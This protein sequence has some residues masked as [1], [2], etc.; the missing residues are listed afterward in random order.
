MIFDL[1]VV[2]AGPAGSSTAAFAARQGLRVIMLDRCKF[3][4]D[5]A[6]G[7]GVT[8]P[9]LNV[10][11]RLG[12]LG[13]VEFGGFHQGRGFIFTSPGG[14]VFRCESPHVDGLRPY[15]YNVP[16]RILDYLLVQ[17]AMELGA[18]L[19]EGFRVVE[20]APSALEAGRIRSAD[21]REVKARL[22]VMASGSLS[23]GVR[24]A[25]YPPPRSFG[26]KW[27]AGVRAY[28]DGV[29]G[30]QPGYPEII[31]LPFSAAGYAWIFPLGP[32]RANVG[33]GI[34][35][36]DL[37]AGAPPL[38]SLFQQFVQRHMGPGGRFARARQDG[39]LRGGLLPMG[40]RFGRTVAD[41][42]M[43]VGDAAGFVDPLTGEGI[44]Y[45][46]RSGELAA[47]QGLEALRRGDVSAGA[48]R[49]YEAQWRKDFGWN[50]WIG[51]CLRPWLAR[52]SLIER[53]FKSL[54]RDV[55]GS[56]WLAGIIG[57]LYPKKMLLSPRWIS[58]IIFPQRWKMNV[59]LRSNE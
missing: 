1:A 41:G 57:N 25:G 49:G 48:L 56:Q 16:R 12:V 46:L 52:G 21:G 20:V 38:R 50:L 31:F 34:L 37:S 24:V 28:F 59:R 11:E 17:R 32:E 33:V 36:G 13:T 5:K 22:V 55:R 10:L 23:S 39:P 42:L 40:P 15:G 30:L 9:A 29:Q 4:R 7:D 19:L 54:S 14:M 6:C 51:S 47:A 8:S 26:R 27:C 45:A 44:Y 2:G 58:R 53:G 3:P 18:T 35:L 43:M